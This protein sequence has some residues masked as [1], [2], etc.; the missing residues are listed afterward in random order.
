MDISINLIP[1]VGN[2]ELYVNIKNKP[3]T[4]DKYTYKE[5]GALAKRVTIRWDEMV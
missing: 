2:T 3:L 1:V 4:L 5:K